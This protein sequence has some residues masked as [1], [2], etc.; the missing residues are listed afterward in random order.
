M[1]V[2]ASQEESWERRELISYEFNSGKLTLQEKG[3]QIHL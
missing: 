1:N 3:L 2:L